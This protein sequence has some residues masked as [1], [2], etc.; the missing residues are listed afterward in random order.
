MAE[1]HKHSWSARIVI[2]IVALFI[3]TVMHFGGQQ[4]VFAQD[5]ASSSFPKTGEWAVGNG[6]Y[7]LEL[8]LSTNGSSASLTALS[9]AA[10]DGV[11]EEPTVDAEN[12]VEFY[13]RNQ[14][15]R[16]KISGTLP[17]LSA[18]AFGTFDFREDENYRAA[19]VEIEKQAAEK[20]RKDEEERQLAKAEKQKAEQ[21]KKEE[22][23]L[24]AEAARKQEAENARLAAELK[25]KQ[26]LESARI[27][28]EEDRK[29]KEA[30]ARNKLENKLAE[31]RKNGKAIEKLLGADGRIAIQTAL[32]MEGLLR[33][34]A[35]GVF[36]G[37]T[38]KALKAYQIK[39]GKTATG[40]LTANEAAALTE[41]AKNSEKF[42][43]AEVE[44]KRKAKEA[45]L[46][47][48]AER[49][50]KAEEALL[51]VAQK[52]E[53]D[54]EAKRKREEER[55]RE[56]AEAERKAEEVRAAAEQEEIRKAEQAKKIA[57]SKKRRKEMRK[58]L[59]AEAR[60]K[61]ADEKARIA[62]EAEAKR[63]AAEEAK[64]IAKEKAEL[65]AAEERKRKA[66]LRK[67]ARLELK[68]KLAVYRDAPESKPI[69]DGD[70][71][72]VVFLLNESERPLN[73]IRNLKGDVVFEDGKADICRIKELTLEPDYKVA[74]LDEL[75]GKGIRDF[76]KV[77]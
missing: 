10:R 45:Q 70:D 74:L 77:K 17:V 52:A 11:C 59:A 21:R 1:K 75:E 34:E 69:F 46:T 27:A 28:A 54:A 60:Q 51:T 22:V 30:E 57:E 14:F 49:K 32:K 37:N 15:Y 66:K 12:Y 24:A 63:V 4:S 55:A 44:R 9:P 7:R 65:A 56:A 8:A 67:K 29:R 25:R 31:A 43:A 35:D 3:S 71:D 16:L 53:R 33:D 36:G 23:R 40:Y 50:R 61:R 68:R 26:E 62:A 18:G 47:A 76:G 41:V 19:M 2:F 64:R 6:H 13:C 58:R 5:S 72:D 48:E 73:A 42:L 39:N 20:K 38:R